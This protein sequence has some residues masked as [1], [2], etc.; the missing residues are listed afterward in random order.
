MADYERIGAGGLDQPLPAA[1]DPTKSLLRAADPGLFHAL[2][3]LEHAIERVVGPRF[4]AECA[5]AAPG[6]GIT[7]AVA[8]TLA[9]DP[10]PMLQSEQLGFPLLALYRKGGPLRWRTSA[11]RISECKVELLFALPPMT[12]GERNVL[13]SVRNL[14]RWVVDDR[15]VLGMDPTYAPP[16]ID[17]DT[18]APYVAGKHVWEVSGITKLAW[19]EDVFGD[20]PWSGDLFVPALLMTGVLLERSRAVDGTLLTRADIAIGLGD[21]DPALDDLT[22]ADTQTSIP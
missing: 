8:H 16:G 18:T 21:D 14:V 17:P 5:R 10:A 20:V 1:V 22:V 12:A 9:E 11:H 15:S 19:E 6:L 4:V 13:A 2:G 7:R 3:L